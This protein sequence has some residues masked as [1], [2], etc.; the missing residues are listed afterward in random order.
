MHAG[1]VPYFWCEMQVKLAYKTDILS[2][3]LFTL[4]CIH[5]HDVLIF[6]CCAQDSTDSIAC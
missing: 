3:F 1:S 2:S 4:F 6:R 5:I